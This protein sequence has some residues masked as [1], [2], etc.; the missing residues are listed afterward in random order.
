MMGGGRGN[1]VQVVNI[2]SGL[3]DGLD[4]TQSTRTENQIVI[5]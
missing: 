4:P 5:E 1:D 2:S 3:I